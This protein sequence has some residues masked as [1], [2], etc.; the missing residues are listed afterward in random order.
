V[1]VLCCDTVVA[2]ERYDDSHKHTVWTY[3]PV[4]NFTVAGKGG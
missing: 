3:C 1:T 4:D 2:N